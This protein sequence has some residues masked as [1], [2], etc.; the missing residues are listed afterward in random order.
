MVCGLV[1]LSDEIRRR[2][3]LV[4]QGLTG[5][6]FPCGD[7][8]AFAS[9][10]RR[11]LSNRATLTTLS[12]NARARMATWSPRE[13]VA[14]TVAAIACAVA[15]RRGHDPARAASPDSDSPIPV[16]GSGKP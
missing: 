14:A 9:S 13:N 5:D 16:R 15:R 11:L 10:L 8:E 1:L 2:F 4:Q 6:I 3:D 12:A 7:V